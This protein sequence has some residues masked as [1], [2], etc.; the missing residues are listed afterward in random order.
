MADKN[1]SP[2]GNFE[3]VAGLFGSRGRHREDTAQRPWLDYQDRVSS[4]AARRKPMSEG[5]VYKLV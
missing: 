2:R 1:F 4:N 5:G 3:S